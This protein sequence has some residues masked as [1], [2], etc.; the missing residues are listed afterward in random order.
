VH[1]PGIIIPVLVTGLFLSEKK[2]SRITIIK[3]ETRQKSR[4]LIL[5]RYKR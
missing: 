1:I 4:A 3:L 5:G 2:S